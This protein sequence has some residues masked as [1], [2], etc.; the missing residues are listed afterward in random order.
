MLSRPGTPL[1]EFYVDPVSK[2]KYRIRARHPYVLMADNTVPAATSRAFQDG[3]FY[4]GAELPFEVTRA[5]PKVVTLDNSGLDQ[6]DPN[7]G[8]VGHLVLLSIRKLGKSLDLLGNP[9][10]LVTLI[11]DTTGFWDFDAPEYL[12]T[13]D[14]F[15]PVMVTNSVPVGDAAGGIRVS[16]AFQGSL[17]ELE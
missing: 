2:Q 15:Q 14:G 16:L 13:K 8:G 9:T 5:K 3:S 4:H 17:L 10:R 11:D 12:S 6:A 1:P 7:K